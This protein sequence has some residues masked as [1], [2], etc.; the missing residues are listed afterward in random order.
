MIYWWLSIYVMWSKE[1]EP[2]AKTL[3]EYLNIELLNKE[4]VHFKEKQLLKAE[5]E[6]IISNQDIKYNFYK[7]QLIRKYKFKKSLIYL[8][9]FIL[10]IN[11][12][13]LIYIIW[14]H[15]I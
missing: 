9:Y 2:K 14:N 1:S 11:I 4:Q 12:I 8:N 3:N 6:T 5:Y 13:S 7:K 15:G 10:I